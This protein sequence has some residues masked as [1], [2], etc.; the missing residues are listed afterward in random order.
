[1]EWVKVTRSR[2]GSDVYEFGRTN[3]MDGWM[4]KR[5]VVLVLVGR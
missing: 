1:M 3:T 4:E 5:L 2:V